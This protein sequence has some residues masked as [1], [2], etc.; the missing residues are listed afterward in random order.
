[1]MFID[2]TK[3]SIRSDLSL[4]SKD[5]PAALVDREG[6]LRLDAVAAM[7]PAGLSDFWGLECRLNTDEP[8]ADIL[9]EVKD[10]TAGQRLLAGLSPSMLDSLCT[11][12]PLWQ[13]LRSFAKLWLEEP[14]TVGRHILNLWLEFDTE[15]LSSYK[16]ASD[17]IQKL[18]IFIGFRSDHVTRAEHREVLHRAN[19]LMRFPNSHIES[20]QAFM[21]SLPSTGRLFQLGSMLGRDSRDV[22]VCV[23]RLQAGDVSAWLKGIGWNGDQQRLSKLLKRLS[24]LLRAFAVDLNLEA[25]GPSKK[26]GIECYMDWDDPEPAQWYVLLD[27]LNELGVCRPGKR[28]GLLQYP[29]Q[30]CLP[31]AQRKACD[32]NL[33]LSLFKTIHHIKLSFNGSYVSDAKAYLAVY[34]PCIQ[35]KNNWFVQ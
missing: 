13:E 9:F 28:E 1:M 32:G 33:Y 8:L 5:I 12:Y 30:V 11:K 17:I 6:L 22:R 3:E 25:D 29:G 27:L 18:S 21:G 19:K 35:P 23:N 4:I 15:D 34:R 31:A 16:D 2:R 14:D 26:I 7:L 20:L 10:K 24:P